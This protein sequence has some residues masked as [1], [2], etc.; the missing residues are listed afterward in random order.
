MTYFGFTR[1]FPDR[2]NDRGFVR[3]GVDCAAAFPP[4]GGMRASGAGDSRAALKP[5]VCACL[6]KSMN[7]ACRRLDHGDNDEAFAPPAEFAVI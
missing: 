1:R 5:G 2:G 4:V 6:R 3:S 7:A